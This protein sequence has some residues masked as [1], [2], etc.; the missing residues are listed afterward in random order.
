MN[1]ASAVFDTRMEADQAVAEL[2]SAGVQDRSIS[3]IAR[4][5]DGSRAKE[6]D[7]AGEKVRDV[8]GK[9]ALGAGIGAALG[10]AA[11][12]I[13]GVGPFVAAGAIAEFAIGGAAVTGTALGAAAGG[14]AGLLSKHGVSDEDARYYET[15]VNDGG[16]FI[17]V[18]AAASGITPDVV[19]DILYRNGGHSSGRSRIAT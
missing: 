9:G 12:A 3:L 15:R 2:R 7:G 1:I 19:S 13:P 17:S 14:L 6:T 5:E 4:D 18:D 16:I 11:L 8:V 10:V